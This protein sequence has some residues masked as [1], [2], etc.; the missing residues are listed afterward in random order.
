MKGSIQKRQG[1]RGVA[2]MARVEF[3]A[4]PITGERRQRAKT[5][6]TRKEAERALSQWLVE[7]DR[8]TALE[9]T[10]TTVSELLDHWLDSVAKFN[11]QSRTLGDYRSTIDVHLKPGLGSILVQKLSTVQI[12]AFYA[13][14][15]DDGAGPR[16][17]ELCHRR[18]S[19]ALDQAVSWSIVIR[20]VC[21]QVKPPRVT[22]KRPDV[23]SRDEL[24]A[25]LDA[26]RD[27]GL[28][29][30]WGLAAA[31]GMR[32]GELLGLRW[33]DLDLD[34][35]LLQ[36][37]QTVTV[38]KGE[39]RGVLAIGAPKT[40]ASRRKI[41]IDPGTIDDLKAH[42]KVQLAQRI[43]AS[44][45]ED[46]DLV[47]CTESG[48]PVHPSN[49]SRSFVRLIAGAKLRRIRF[50]DI[51]HTHA[52]L[53]LQAGTPIKVVSERLG[54]AKTSITMGI[55]AHVLPDMQDQ[56]VETISKMLFS[57]SA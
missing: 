6:R 16:T 33:R 54:H 26:S 5:F 31:T 18:L 24:L 37:E 48:K 56:A 4:D 28:A 36:V 17:V 35:G 30:L 53:L 23:W 46:N 22:H 8:G 1:A 15:L 52:T 43:G 20:N 42:R 40:T 3:S 45:W 50:H 19:Q 57:K 7:I 10:K 12:Q 55:Y 21:D 38:M 25:F 49:V 29:P 34:G 39:K 14:K 27:D 11:V 44:V 51:R 41:R 32:L 2:Y 13:K 9:P 47:F